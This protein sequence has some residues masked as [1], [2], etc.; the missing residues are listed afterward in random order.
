M[1]KK[2]LKLI[3]INWKGDGAFVN[4]LLMFFLY[5]FSF[6]FDA[7]MLYSDVDV[8]YNLSEDLTSI[9]NLMKVIKY[10]LLGYL[11]L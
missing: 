5:C 1:K 6:C 7:M 9:V 8:F 10:R 2:N 4:L 11:N 3:Q